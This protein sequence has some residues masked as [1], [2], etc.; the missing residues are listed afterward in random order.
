MAYETT[1]LLP[2]G[3][4][5]T[6][7]CHVPAPFGRSEQYLYKM[8]SLSYSSTDNA[9]L[10]LDLPLDMQVNKARL[11]FQLNQERK[12]RLLQYVLLRSTSN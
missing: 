3:L 4:I 2:K 12:A 1:G 11:A 10:H 9:A 5:A 8:K 7:N 6:K